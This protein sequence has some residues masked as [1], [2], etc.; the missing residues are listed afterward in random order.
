MREI[1]NCLFGKGY[2]SEKYFLNKNIVKIV[3]LRKT[4]S[5]V[6]YGKKVKM[7]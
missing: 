3:A 1:S 2:H 6:F 4:I 5:L 7:W